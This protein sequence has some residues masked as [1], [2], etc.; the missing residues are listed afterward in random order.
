MSMTSRG[1]DKPMCHADTKVSH[2]LSRLLAHSNNACYVLMW[3]VVFW[4][5]HNMFFRAVKVCYRWNVHNV[6]FKAFLCLLYKNESFDSLL[7]NELQNW[8]RMQV[9]Y[10][11]FNDTVQRMVFFVYYSDSSNMKELVHIICHFIFLNFTCHD[12]RNI[13]RYIVE[14]CQHRQKPKR[15]IT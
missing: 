15:T 2:N 6:Q 5:R 12:K 11:L 9:F 3:S 1:S 10:F 8:L 13:T 7:N 14:P 4:P